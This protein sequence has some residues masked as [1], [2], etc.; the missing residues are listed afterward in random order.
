[1]SEATPGVIVRCSL[2]SSKVIVPEL[3]EKFVSGVI[4]RLKEEVEC[5]VGV[6]QQFEAVQ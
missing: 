6:M 3:N 1:M 2:N 5:L 4:G